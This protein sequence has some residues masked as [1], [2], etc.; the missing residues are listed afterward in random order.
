MGA[1]DGGGATGAGLSARLHPLTD[2]KRTTNP[3]ALRTMHTSTSEEDC[4][5]DATPAAV[6]RRSG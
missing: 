1:A 6:S 3:S 4:N 5:M 2:D